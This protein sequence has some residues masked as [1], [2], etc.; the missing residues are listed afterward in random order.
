MCSRLFLS[1]ALHKAALCTTH[2]ARKGWSSEMGV[3]RLLAILWEWA[4]ACTLLPVP[5]CLWWAQSV[6]S[7]APVIFLP[8]PLLYTQCLCGGVQCLTQGSHPACLQLHI[9]TW[10]SLGWWVCPASLSAIS[11]SFLLSFSQ[12]L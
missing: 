3:G 2:G 10:P 12:L 9:F 11:L 8:P 4:I 1:A 7:P 6:F 5:N